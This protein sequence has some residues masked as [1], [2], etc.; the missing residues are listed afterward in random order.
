MTSSIPT[1]QLAGK[2]EKDSPVEVQ[3]IQVPQPGDDELLIQITATAIN[4][5]SQQIP[6]S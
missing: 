2:A 5:V 1:T 6:Y 3:Q 4:P